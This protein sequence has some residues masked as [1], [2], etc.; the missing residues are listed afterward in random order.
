MA[1][2]GRIKQEA[3]SKPFHR[4]AS[5]SFV[6][7][8]KRYWSTAMLAQCLP[9]WT[10][11][12]AVEGTYSLNYNLIEHLQVLGKQEQITRENI[13]ILTRSYQCLAL[14]LQQE[15]AR[16][17]NQSRWFSST[18]QIYLLV[19]QKE[20]EN[21]EIR[22]ADQ[23]AYLQTKACEYCREKPVMLEVMLFNNQ[24]LGK[25]YMLNI[26]LELMPYSPNQGS[27]WN[28]WFNLRGYYAFLS[29]K[30]DLLSP[31]QL[32]LV[33]PMADLA[34]MEDVEQKLR[35]EQ[36]LAKQQLKQSWFYQ[37]IWRAFL[38]TWQE[39]LKSSLTRLAEGKALW[40]ERLNARLS[41]N[42]E[43]ITQDITLRL[44]NLDPDKFEYWGIDVIAQAQEKLSQLDADICE[45]LRAI[46]KMTGGINNLNVKGKALYN[47]VNQWLEKIKRRQ[48]AFKSMEWLSKCKLTLTELY[49][50]NSNLPVVNVNNFANDP[51]I[52]KL[53]E[54]KTTIEALANELQKP[55]ASLREHKVCFSRW[56][57]YLSGCSEEMTDIQK[58]MLV[59]LY[60]RVDT[61][62]SSSAS[63]AMQI[64]DFI[65]AFKIS[66]DKSLLSE[67]AQ[68]IIQWLEEALSKKIADASPVSAL[69]LPAQPE[70][71]ATE[72]RLA[73]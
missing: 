2:F 69:Y 59:D 61:Y 10:S 51:F 67:N 5:Q 64:Q 27:L 40:H 36:A 34:R 11:S 15:Q 20:C 28:W 50:L 48:Q 47:Q 56:Q 41:Q 24:P 42:V 19:W 60:D 13:Q 6:F 62:D 53:D 32:P 26:P 57:Q 72:I 49:S 66:A 35:A 23:L 52:K 31:L 29:A 4:Y 25:S 39:T 44:T 37:I 1:S 54:F 30:Q 21:A 65:A 7:K 68:L 43:E 17:E 14:K 33:S 16:I 12:S 73:I 8:N 3:P 45:Q 71:Q 22:V 9:N 55:N 63:S 58:N 38:N 18:Q 70:S 46:D